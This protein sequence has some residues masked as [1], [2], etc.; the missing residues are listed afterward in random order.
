MDDRA[1]MMAYDL[2]NNTRDAYREEWKEA[3]SEKEKKR[4]E[5]GIN[6]YE[7]MKQQMQ[8]A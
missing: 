7:A 1:M 3:R 2:F 8:L 5:K 4:K 6:P